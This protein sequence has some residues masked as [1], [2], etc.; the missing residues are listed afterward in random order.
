MVINEKEVA[1]IH[2]SNL[3]HQ[4]VGLNPPKSSFVLLHL[5]ERSRKLKISGHFPM[6][7]RWDCACIRQPL[8]KANGTTELFKADIVSLR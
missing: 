4:I 3:D 8:R 6:N 5:D 7:N 1:H 2:C